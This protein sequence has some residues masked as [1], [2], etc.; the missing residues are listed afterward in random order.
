VFRQAFSRPRTMSAAIETS[1]SAQSGI[2]N[3][4][5]SRGS[6]IPFFLEQ[7]KTGILPI[8]D[9]GMTRF[10]ISLQDAVDMVLWALEH[11]LGG[12]IFVP[13]IPSYR[14]TDLA[15]AIGPECEQRLVGIRPG[16]KIHEEMITASDS[17]NT[18]DL[19]RYYAILPSSGR[20][21]LEDYAAATGAVRVEA[22]FSYSSGTNR[23][24]LSVGAA[25]R[26]NSPAD[27]SAR[28]IPY[29]RSAHH[30]SR[31][32]RGRGG[33]AVRLSHAR[34]GTTPLRGRRGGI[35]WR[36]ARGGGQQRDL[37]IAHRLRSTGLGAGWT[38]CVTSPNT[39][40][41]SANCG[42]YCGARVDFV[43]IDPRTYNLDPVALAD[44]WSRR[45]ATAGCRK[46]SFLCISRVRA[47]TWRRSAHLAT[48]TSFALS[49]TPRMPIG[50]RYRDEPVGSCRY[51][52]IT[53]FSFHPVKVITTPRA[54]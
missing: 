51:S 41:A 2:G 30:P 20:F 28:M 35:L 40:V 37:G 10:T 6:V 22:G 31:H 1:D 47:A 44:S 9:A 43:D 39:F 14:I 3:V 21:S 4:M 15:Q 45:S 53:V 16:E 52:D 49:K 7:R 19:G 12:E 32:R 36:T 26:I 38:G 8:T 25:S 46:S 5:G 18:M 50:G 17:F 42:L 11:A 34:T 24:F 54:A 29:G 23:E 33:A 27:R 48:A 13:K